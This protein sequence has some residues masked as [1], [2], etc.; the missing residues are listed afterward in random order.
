MERLL[1]WV[2]AGCL[3]GAISALGVPARAQAQHLE[4]EFRDEGWVLELSAGMALSLNKGAYFE[5]LQQF[6]FEEHLDMLDLLRVSV[7]AGRRLHPHLLVG[8]SYFNLGASEYRRFVEFAQHFAWV[9]HGFGVFAQADHS[10]GRRRLLNIFGRLGAGL[11]AAA[12]RF[13]AVIA[14]PQQTDPQ[15]VRT[16]V[17]EQS[18][19]RACGW[20]GAGVQL[21]PS[22]F[23]GVQ[24]EVRYVV[25]P[26]IDN[27]IGET[28]QLGGLTAMGGLRLRTWE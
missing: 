14:S 5:R 3:I 27:E 16:H 9:A 8:G 23:V 13:D 28:Q 15:P 24:F 10:F 21:M 18:Y 25:A 20:I 1:A 2:W 11:S 6:G 26:G 7:S 12:T 22:R 4:P 19:L 17:V